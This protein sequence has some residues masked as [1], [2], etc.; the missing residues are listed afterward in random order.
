VKVEG[1]FMGTVRKIVN[2]SGKASW[3]IDYK[4]PAGKRIRQTLK[5]KK[6]ADAELGKRVALIAEN[7][8]LDVKKDYLTTLDELLKKYEENFQHQASFKNAKKKY[9]ENFREYFGK[10]TML[11]NIRYMELESYRNHLKQKPVGTVKRGR[12]IILR[13]RSDAS[14]NREMS[15]LHHIFTKAVEWEM[16][17]RSPFERGKSLIL[18]ENNKRMRFLNE[19][20]ID[21]LIPACPP[22]LRHVVECGINTGMRRGE[23]LSLRWSQ[24]RG[25]FIYLSKTKTNEARQIPINDD[26]Q[27]VF[28][29]IRSDQ[30]PKASILL[31]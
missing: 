30:N 11:A 18:K 21:R 6:D 3:Q 15:C 12:E 20:E 29:Q 25:G 22:H 26:L 19:A 14:V 13:L 9:L 27:K 4:D 24:I 31:I 2:K 17:E 16:V 23:I 7:R 5:K 10:K 1:T 28:N 8:Y